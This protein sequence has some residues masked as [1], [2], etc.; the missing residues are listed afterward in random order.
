MGSFGKVPV[1]DAT[2]R[3]D[4]AWKRESVEALKRLGEAAF[5][6]SFYLSYLLSFLRGLGGLRGDRQLSDGSGEAALLPCYVLRDA[7]FADVLGIFG[8]GQRT[9]LQ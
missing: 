5:L 2:E 8:D 7:L 6:L 1:L 3:R 4:A 9:T